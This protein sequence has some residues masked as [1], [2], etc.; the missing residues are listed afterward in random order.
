MFSALPYKRQCYHDLGPVCLAD[1]PYTINLNSGV[2]PSLSGI[3]PLKSLTHCR[4][5]QVG[6][7]YAEFLKALHGMLYGFGLCVTCAAI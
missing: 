1:T 3:N 2:S 7:I 5:Q 6:S 4:R